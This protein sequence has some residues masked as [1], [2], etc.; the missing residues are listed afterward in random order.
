MIG[1]GVLFTFMPGWTH[2]VKIYWSILN[3]D[4]LYFLAYQFVYLTLCGPYIDTNELRANKGEVL[5]D[6]GSCV[7]QIHTG[8]ARYIEIY[9][10]I[11]MFGPQKSCRKTKK[12]F[13]KV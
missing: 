10:C 11:S 8:W 3:I 12:L 1:P 13:L 7:I 2:Y 9:W 4:R 5:L 6:W